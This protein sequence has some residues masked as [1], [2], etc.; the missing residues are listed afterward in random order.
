MGIVKKYT[1]RIEKSS[2]SSDALLTFKNT[3]YGWIVKKMVYHGAHH[4]ERQG[5]MG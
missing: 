5:L 3:S 4:S 2:A 1:F